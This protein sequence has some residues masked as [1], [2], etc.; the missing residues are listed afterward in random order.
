[1]VSEKN[2]YGKFFTSACVQCTYNIMYGVLIILSNQSFIPIS[3][4]I[5]YLYNFRSRAINMIS[6]NCIHGL[7]IAE[8]MK[9]YRNICAVVVISVIW[10]SNTELIYHVQCRQ[11]LYATCADGTCNNR[12]TQYV[13]YVYCNIVK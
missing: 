3:L 8:L 12:R 5:V 2:Q 9:F 1:M 4:H 6:N 11:T 13:S 7:Y 10:T